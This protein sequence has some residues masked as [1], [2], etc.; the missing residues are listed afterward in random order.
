MENI[1]IVKTITLVFMQN[2][3]IVS[4]Y[5]NVKYFQINIQISTV[6][7]FKVNPIQRFLIKHFFCEQLKVAFT[8][9]ISFSLARKDGCSKLFPQYQTHFQIETS[10]SKWREFNK[11]LYNA[12][13]VSVLSLKKKDWLNNYLIINYGLITQLINA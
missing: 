7:L 2:L 5:S 13:E 12:L 10:I 9:N 6:I 4:K 8:Q 11:R 3:R 1:P